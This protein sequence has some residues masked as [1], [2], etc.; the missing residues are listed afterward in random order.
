M[1]NFSYEPRA[2]ESVDGKSLSLAISRKSTGCIFQ[3]VLGYRQRQAR[4]S[5][6]PVSGSSWEVC[7]HP[8]HHRLL[9]PWSEDEPEAFLD[10][11]ELESPQW[12][13]SCWRHCWAKWRPRAGLLQEVYSC[14]DGAREVCSTQCRC[15]QLARIPPQSGNWRLLATCCVLVTKT[16]TIRAGKVCQTIDSLEI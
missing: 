14:P 2:Y 8:T 10:Q 9:P 11:T 6:L 12:P 3:G 13:P 4:L 16:K 15:C 1:K 7:S 5:I